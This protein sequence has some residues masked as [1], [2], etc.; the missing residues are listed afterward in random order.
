MLIKYYGTAH[1]VLLHLAVLI[2]FVKERHHWVASSYQEEQ[3]KIY[4]NLFNG[5]LAPS[6]EVQ[7]YSF[8]V[9]LL[10]EL[11]CTGVSQSYDT[12]ALTMHKLVIMRAL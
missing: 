1:F 6:L 7:L 2:H 11:L 10:Q 12:S 5:K 9:L 4:D 8:T 3:V